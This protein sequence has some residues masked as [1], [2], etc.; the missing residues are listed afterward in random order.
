MGSRHRP[1][2]RVVVSDSRRTPTAASVEEVGFYDPRQE[3]SVI[4]IDAD[5]VAYWNE[6][7]AQISDAVKKLIRQSSRAPAPAA[8]APEPAAEAV[9]E[10]EVTE[11]AEATDAA[12]VTEAADAAAS[13]SSDMSDVSDETA[14]APEATEAAAP[15]ATGAAAPEATEAAAPEAT[16]AAAPEATEAA[17]PETTEEPPA[18]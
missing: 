1:F 11:A 4:A 6:R 9:I 2:F 8:V 17:A 7:G 15:E 3:P 18:T 13:D 5:R 14:L 16:G 12:A 10:A